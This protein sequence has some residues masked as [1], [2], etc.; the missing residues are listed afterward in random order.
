MSTT[1][2][3]ARIAGLGHFVPEHIV[4]NDDLAK[5]VETS[6]EWIRSRTGI[7]E[8]HFA[9][10]GEST[11][12]MATN[13]GREAIEAAGVAPEQ[14]GLLIIATSTPDYPLFPS[15]A[16]LVQS[17]LGLTQAGAFD[18]SAACSGFVYGLITASQFIT[19]GAYEH[20]L[21]IGADTLSRFVDFTDR[22]T[23]VLFADGA[24]AAVVSASPGPGGLRSFVLGADGD[25]ADHLIVPAG[26]SRTPLTAESLANH[27]QTIHMNGREVYRFSTTTPI[28]ALEE[29]A[30]RAGVAIG[31]L[32][33]VV[34]HQANER[35][36][37][38][39]AK[40]LGVREE[41]FYSNVN[42]LGNT[43]AA[44]VPLALYDAAASGRIR[45][46]SCV[47]LMGFGA[48]LTWATAIWHWQGLS[49]PC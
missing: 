37:Q 6:D 8:R 36:L 27:G 15:T 42:R 24:G 26:G 10:E 34:A 2:R 44:S 49:S 38:T 18:L 45:A 46:G 25:G 39:A 12:T 17:A 32:D 22:T 16:C 43:S 48:G 47:G 29:A 4:T 35:I 41:L 7:A 21:V 13:A 20:V 33:L 5:L 9:G 40:N 14:I 30:R 23:C 1:E 31:D 11:A 3:Y 28:L 19:G